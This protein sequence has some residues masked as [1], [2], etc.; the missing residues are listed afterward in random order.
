MGLRTRLRNFLGF[1]PKP[2]PAPA[3]PLRRQYQGALISRLT[4]DWLATQTSA[5]AEIRTSLRKLRDRSRELVRN[6]P[7]AKQAK[8]TTQVNVIGTGVKLQAQIPQ[9]RGN[10]RDTRLEKL[11]EAKWA[12]W[13]RA[14]NCDVAGRNNFHQQEWLAA[15]AL[16]E[17]GEA[18]FRI[19]RQRFGASKVPLALQQLE[20]DLLD[21]EYNG[22]TLAPANEWR[23]GVEVNEWGRPV[24]YAIL[25]RHPGDYWFQNAGQQN[26][27]HIFINARDIIH[28]F[29]PERPGQNRGVPWFH[30]VMADAH[31]LQGYEEAAVIRA[32]AGASIMGFITNQEGELHPDA[33]ENNQRISEFEPG[34]FKYLNPGEGVTVPDID[35][36]DDQFDAFVKNKVRR[37]AAGFG[38]SY[39]TLSRDFSETSYSSARTATLEDRDHWRVIQAYIIEN[40]HMRVFREWLSLAV[41]AGELPFADYEL[42]PERYDTPMWIPRG[43]DWVDP[44]KEVR[45]YR[46]A[47]Q[48]GY[49]TKTE[50]VARNGGD[51]DDNIATISREQQIASEAKVTLDRDIIEP[52]PQLTA[53]P[54]ES[55]PTRTKRRRSTPAT[56]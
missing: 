33:I 8:R 5:D 3:A 19:V 38:C 1:A 28:L 54:P 36:P 10:K 7:Y 40:F 26:V 22:A 56:D 37:F 25:T 43:W 55:P 34:M 47:E 20:S 2:V 24:R 16:P 29:L 46:E 9:L 27:K 53:P 48:A 4:S 35:S 45:A 17:S 12:Y 13:C 21:E 41:L 50:I 11:L 18:I 42:R 49:I 52:A 32:R 39:E 6:N 44:L 14:E 30:P 51:F 15:G 31:Q 23:N